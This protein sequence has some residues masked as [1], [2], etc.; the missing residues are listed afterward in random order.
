MLT[1]QPRYSLWLRKESLLVPI[2]SSGIKDKS[3]PY[4]TLN[5][6][7]QE[8]CLCISST[9]V[10]TTIKVPFLRIMAISPTLRNLVLSVGSTPID[11]LSLICDLDEGE[12]TALQN[13]VLYGLI[14]SSGKKTVKN[15]LGFL[16]LTFECLSL[17]KISYSHIKLPVKARDHN[18]TIDHQPESERSLIYQF[19][20]KVI[21]PM[22]LQQKM[23]IPKI[24]TIHI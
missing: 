18:L 19:K 23:Y 21:L 15:I 9:Q 12:M 2:S 16:G 17:T 7:Y 24:W 3:L 11:D 8:D 1:S 13:F 5:N 4:L 20:E 6:V 14:V 10:K 22:F